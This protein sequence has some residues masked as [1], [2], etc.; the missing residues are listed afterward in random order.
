MIK[1]DIEVRAAQ[2]YV[3]RFQRILTAARDRY[4]PETYEAMATGYLAEIECVIREII[5][6]FRR[7]PS[8]AAASCQNCN[9]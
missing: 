3:L 1:S 4:A 2:E 6:Y 8:K 9:C 7:V 5:E